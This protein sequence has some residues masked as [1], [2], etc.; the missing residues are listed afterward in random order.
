MITGRFLC[1][2]FLSVASRRLVAPAVTMN[3]QGCLSCRRTSRPIGSRAPFAFGSSRSCVL[4]LRF[5][6]RR[7][8]P[9]SRI[10]PTS[11][12]RKRST[13]YS[14]RR[15][16]RG[17]LA[18]LSPIVANLPRDVANAS[19]GFLFPQYK[20]TLKDRVLLGNFVNIFARDEDESRLIGIAAL[21]RFIGHERRDPP[22]L[23]ERVKNNL[24]NDGEGRRK[25]HSNRTQKPSEE[26]Q[27]DQNDQ[28]R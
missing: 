11:R 6:R 19:R 10:I 3:R 24:H 28:R 9:Y 16:R 26:D 1:T 27:R 14:P 17:N 25:E 21:R 22:R 2:E 5:L 23:G 15:N 12:V 4:R 7:D 18:S 20:N 13:T 8:A